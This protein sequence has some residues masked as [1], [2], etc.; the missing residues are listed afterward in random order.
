MSEETPDR[1]DTPERAAEKRDRQ[2]NDTE[3]SAPGDRE[4]RGDMTEESVLEGG[5]GHIPA[6]SD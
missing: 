5:A 3:P 6:R 4:T 1:D 2:E